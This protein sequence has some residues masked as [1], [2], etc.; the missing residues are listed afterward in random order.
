MTDKID[1]IL[2]ELREHK[3]DSKD[4]QAETRD[5]FKEVNERLSR[6]EE[7]LLVYKTLIRAS[8]WL[9]ALLV[10]LLTL[11]WGDIPSLFHWGSH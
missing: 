4:F 11:K 6:N 2:Q 1:L 3:N 5:K 10:L 9:G 8:Q 7:Q